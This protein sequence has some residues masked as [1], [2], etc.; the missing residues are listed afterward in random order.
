MDEKHLT[1][2]D[3]ALEAKVGIGTVSRVLNNSSHITET[4][5][6]AV[7]D[8]I[9]AHNYQPNGVAANL[10]RK[11]KSHPF[12]G[13]LLP[14]IANHY[15]FEV[16]ETIYKVLKEQNIHLIILNYDEEDGQAIPRIL[17]TNLSALMLFAVKPSEQELKLLTARNVPYLYLD[18]F[19]PEA[20]CIHMD[21]RLGG[22]L[23]A[24]YLIDKKVRHP[25]FIHG[26]SKALTDQDRYKGF[27][28]AVR[29]A[30][31]EE[32]L[33]YNADFKEIF[34]YQLAKTLI[35]EGKTDGIFCFCDEQAIG[36]LKAI[37]ESKAPIRVIG[38][39][40]IKESE[41]WGLSTI[42][43]NPVTIGHQAAQAIINLMKQNP[44]AK[45]INIQLT[46]IV[47]DRDS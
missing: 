28:E 2:K 26:D 17:E 14:D 27:R 30:G 11:T 21:N 42:S 31:L 43:Q 4:T 19:F 3:I 35:A 22:R 36:V 34:G 40:G 1:I 9:H 46:P 23:A 8:V 12:I 15:F 5:R 10:A 41:A 47:I 45:T 29:E 20:N 33:T 32:P 24:Q 39:D 6:K 44:I 18:Y 25:C 7:M 13:I 38:Y 16:V 37:R